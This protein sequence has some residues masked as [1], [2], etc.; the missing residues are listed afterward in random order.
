LDLPREKAGRATEAAEAEAHHGRE[1]TANRNDLAASQ[2]SN[3][4]L[5]RA[6][7]ALT[8]S[9]AALRESQERLRLILDSTADYV[10]FSMDTERRVASW[11]AGAKRLLG[12]SEE[13][14]LGRSADVIFTPE[15]RE[16]GAPEEEGDGALRHGRAADERWHQ[17]KDGS[18]FWANGLMLPLRDPEAGPA[19]PPLGLLKVMRD[20]TGRRRAEEALRE[21]EARWRGLFERMQEGFA[22]CEMVY[23]ADGQA[24]DYRHLELNAA[25]GG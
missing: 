19:A 6:N 24:V 2:E 13:E 20:E 11:N 12:W 14:I 23:D 3:A 8:E 21:G 17:R 4:A 25:W 22:L 10:I 16:A 15:D 5:R 7:L 1:M 18:R 9:R